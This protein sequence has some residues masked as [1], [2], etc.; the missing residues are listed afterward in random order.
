M[1]NLI[2]EPVYPGADS[3]GLPVDAVVITPGLSQRLI[4]PT[5]QLLKHK[6]VEGVTINVMVVLRKRH[7]KVGDRAA[8]VVLLCVSNFRWAQLGCAHELNGMGAW[9]F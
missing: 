3:H 9:L 4:Q 5:L 7:L 6:V 2:F 1:T 8:K